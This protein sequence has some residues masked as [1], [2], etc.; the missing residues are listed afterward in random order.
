M[1]VHAIGALLYGLS[2]VGCAKR[3][4]SVSPLP[5]A[6]AT[7]AASAGTPPP[8]PPPATATLAAPVPNHCDAEQAKIRT[9]ADRRAG[10]RGVQTHLAEHF[11]DGK[12]SWLMKLCD[13]QTYVAQKNAPYFGRPLGANQYLF[14]GPTADMKK[15][16]ADASSGGKHDPAKL[17][18]S[19]GLSPDNMKGPLIML[20]LDLSTAGA[21]VRLPV[22]TDPGA[23]ACCAAGE[24]DCFKFGG[25]T[26]GGMPEVMIINA[27]TAYATLDIVL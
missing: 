6:T 17:A 12:V 22:E 25:R 15:A 7:L 14:A 2:A 23:K 20:T 13:Y 18:K 21:C 27:P 26:S 4:A 16:V 24:D 3:E 5:P 8:A 1:K 10:P 9:E 11:K 19:L